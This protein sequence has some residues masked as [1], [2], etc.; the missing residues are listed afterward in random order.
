[1]STSFW[2][3]WREDVLPSR[4][5]AGELFLS[6]CGRRVIL[7]RVPPAVLAA[8]QRL[9]SPGEDEE[10]LAEIFT[11]EDRLSE[12]YYCL[13]RLKRLLCRSVFADGKCLAT[14]VPIAPLAFTSAVIH[15]DRPYR[16][17]RFAY[18]R[19]QG[20]NLVLESPLTRFRIILADCRSVALVAALAM[21]GTVASLQSPA[22]DLSEE[23]LF[24]ILSLLVDA[25]MVQEGTQENRGEAECAALEAWEF[26]DLLFH[27]RSRRGRSDGHFGGTYWLAGLQ[28]G[29]AALKRVAGCES[30]KLYEP[31]LETL[32]REDPPLAQ[33]QESRKSIRVY[34]V[35]PITDRQLGEFL[36]RIA[37]VRGKCEL[38]VSTP[39][40]LRKIELTSRPYPA[41]GA[42][43][44]LEF[45][46]AVQEC[47]NLA[48]GLY[49][50]EPDTHGL[51]RLRERT[52]DVGQL[53]RDAALSASIPVERLQVLIVLTSR[54]QRI[55]WKYET[56]AYAL[57][58]KHVGVVYQSM[59]LAATA[60]NLAPCA[61]GGGDSDLFAKAAGIDYY[62]ESSVGEF[63]LGS[64]E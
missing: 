44:E 18:M 15:P 14:M 45:Y 2:L 37:R 1:V 46:V 36:Y 41:G 34:G 28:D 35:K 38:E 3:S 49:H 39:C 33:V 43:Y 63:L 32:Q 48:P 50:Y 55:A 19:C 11:D 10:R 62:A 58:L 23:A 53:L 9:N 25:G 21:N 56:I 51:T 5:D 22:C 8:L 26:H 57:T 42:L 61:L 59:Y 12:W 7:R 13:D 20:N 30:L 4:G 27:T 29:P 31:N 24:K 52:K 64:R 54:H 16:L 17:S 47:E 60:M 6:D 40:G